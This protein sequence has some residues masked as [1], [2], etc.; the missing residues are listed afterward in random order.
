MV[1]V[2]FEE[3]GRG[4]GGGRGDELIGTHIHVFGVSNIYLGF[5]KVT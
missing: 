1:V 3:G 4:K 2:A 5:L